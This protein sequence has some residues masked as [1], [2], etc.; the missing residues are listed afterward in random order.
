MT[1]FPHLYEQPWP[2]GEYRLFQLGFVTPDLFATAARWAEVFG[3]GP[4][5]VLPSRETEATLHGEPAPLEMQ[6][7]VAQAGPTQIELITQHCDRPS[8]YREMQARGG[9]SFHQVCTV[10]ADYAANVAH[11]EGLGY[12][13]ASEIVAAGQ[14]VA[15]IDTVDDFGFY[16]EVVE[17]VPG[18]V[19]ALTRISET[20]ATWDGTDPV[21]ILTRDGYRVP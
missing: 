13:V 15:F 19:D 21:R 10:T 7:A 17:E 18:F 16:T 14:H 2:E 4:F 1:T 11:Y 3:V 12:E 9:S 20:C 6:V 5:H 8:I